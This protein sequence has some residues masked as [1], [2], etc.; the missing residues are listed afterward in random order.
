VV[1]VPEEDPAISEL[2]DNPRVV[3]VDDAEWDVPVRQTRYPPVRK[4]A[5]SVVNGYHDAWQMKTC[6]FRL[7]AR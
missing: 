1:K 4:A 2:V 5:G 7:P 6:H 3:P